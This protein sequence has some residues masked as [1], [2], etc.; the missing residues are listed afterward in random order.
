MSRPVGF[1]G[2][3]QLCKITQAQISIHQLQLQSQN[4]TFII[5]KHYYLHCSYALRPQ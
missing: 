1:D 3:I 2:T 5:S 4:D